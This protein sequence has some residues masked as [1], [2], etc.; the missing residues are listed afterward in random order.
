MI[1]ALDKDATGKFLQYTL[2]HLLL[3]YDETTLQGE[4]HIWTQDWE[5]IEILKIYHIGEERYLAEP[6]PYRARDNPLFSHQAH[7]AKAEEYLQ[8]AKMILANTPNEVNITECGRGIT[9]F[10]VRLL[11]LTPDVCK[12]QASDSDPRYKPIL[13][14]YFPEV[15]W[16]E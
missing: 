15:E 7:L 9:I 4:N 16:A 12:I 13:L 5:D 10:L 1:K 3:D 6:I 2:F 11:G 8:D 14:G